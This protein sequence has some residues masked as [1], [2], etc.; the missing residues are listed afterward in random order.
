MPKT[1]LEKHMGG[2]LIK[3]ISE[4]GWECFPEV[5]LR[6]RGPRA[7][8]IATKNQLLWAVEIKLSLNMTVIEQ[9]LR[10]KQLGALYTSVAVLA[11]M[12]KYHNKFNFYTEFVDRVFRNEGL[13]LFL[14]NRKDMS[15]Q[16]AITPR[17]F[18]YNFSKSKFLMEQLD[19]RMKSYAA[20]SS[21]KE[22]YSSPFRRTIENAINFIAI[23]KKCSIEELTNNIKTHFR[24]RTKAKKFLVK[25]LTKNPNIICHNSGYN[26]VYEYK[27]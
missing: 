23:S 21:S 12:R 17:L 16:E 4:E 20:G 15:V 26:T 5:Q 14:I 6:T 9:A 3:W 24:I 25:H 11:P 7:D 27:E 18:R 19:E 10:W 1:I 22:G 2:N 8:L 13:G